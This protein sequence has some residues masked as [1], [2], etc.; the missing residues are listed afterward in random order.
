VPLESPVS[1]REIAEIG[2]LADPVLRNLRITQVYHELATALAQGLGPENATWCAFATWASKTAGLSIRCEILR[3]AVRTQVE[4]A[5]GLEAA[6]A[7]ANALGGAL[8]ST[9]V[10]R[11]LQFSHVVGLLDDVLERVSESVAQGNRAVFV[12]LAPVF[13]RLL[14]E[15]ASDTRPD[16]D[17]LARFLDAALPDAARQDG[18]RQA[19]SAYY[20]ARFDADPASRARHVL[21][22]NLQAV[23]HEQVRLQGAIAESLDAPVREVLKRRLQRPVLHWVLRCIPIAPLRRRIQQQ[24]DELERELIDLWE[25]VATEHLMSLDTADERFALGSDVP[26]LAG[27]PLFPAALAELDE[28]LERFL[29][30]WDR[31]QG[32]G[33]GSGAR[34]WEELGERMTFIATLFRSRQQHRRLLDEPFGPEQ[35]SALARGVVP[36]GPL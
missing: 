14:D 12:E 6:L 18:L 32:R 19:F 15:L 24:V 31:T 9:G 30:R 5:T 1:R 4:K 7:R 16:A 2:A 17:K 29:A 20:F 8:L 3:Q 34:D 25:R 11:R 26:P 21:L 22:G 28:P 13:A 36:E 27:Q 10:L 23:L 33:V 35:R